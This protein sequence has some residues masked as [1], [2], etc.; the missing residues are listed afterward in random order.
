MSKSSELDELDVLRLG[1]EMEALERAGFFACDARLQ[2]KL[3]SPL[4]FF[5]KVKALDG[6]RTAAV[7]RR[8]RHAEELDAMKRDMQ[9]LVEVTRADAKVCEGVREKM[10]LVRTRFLPQV[11]A[12]MLKMLPDLGPLFREALQRYQIDAKE[13]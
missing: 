5:S 2:E 7:L 12:E 10:N 9:A 8:L 6:E 3:S 11:K 4:R 1:S 13:S